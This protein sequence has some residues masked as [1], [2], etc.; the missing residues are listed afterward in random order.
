MIF[1]VGKYISDELDR[2][3]ALSKWFEKGNPA[4]PNPPATAWDN[5]SQKLSQ[6]LSHKKL[7]QIFG[8]TGKLATPPLRV[9]IAQ[10][11]LVGAMGGLVKPSGYCWHFLKKFLGHEIILGQ[12]LDL[13]TIFG[14]L[15]QFFG[16]SRWAR[17]PRRPFRARPA[18]ENLS[19][20]WY[21]SPRTYRSFPSPTGDRPKKY[22]TFGINFGIIFPQRGPKIV[23]EM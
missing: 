15:G 12:F 14:V 19:G 17:W 3:R 21:W 7:S 13:G 9:S 6:K 2:L 22:S 8:A 4:C 10:I 5:L 16:I 23:P 20:P 11:P 18:A 1:G